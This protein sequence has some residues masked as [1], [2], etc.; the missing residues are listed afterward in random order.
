MY[1]IIIS[2]KA[3]DQLKKVDNITRNRIS[4]IIERLKIRPYSYVKRLVGTPYFRARVGNYRIILNIQNDKLIIIVI[5]IGLR[6]NI[7][8]K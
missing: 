3:K 4:A 5:E 7:Y 6:K 8:K 2:S 1:E